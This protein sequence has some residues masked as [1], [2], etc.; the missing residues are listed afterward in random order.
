MTE[1]KIGSPVNLLVATK[2]WFHA[3]WAVGEAQACEVVAGQLRQAQFDLAQINPTITRPRAVKAQI[4]GHGCG[5]LLAGQPQRW[6]GLRFCRCP[7]ETSSWC[8]IFSSFVSRE[9]C[10]ALQN[11][12]SLVPVSTILWSKLPVQSC[13]LS[14][15]QVSRHLRDDGS[16]D[17]D[18]YVPKDP[19]IEGREPSANRRFPQDLDLSNGMG[20]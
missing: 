16:Q 20:R 3:L 9:Q 17:G 2:G 7:P 12:L 8:L 4:A 14:P 18:E 19:R 13:F 6:V 11:Q 15:K 1:S 5:S 10:L